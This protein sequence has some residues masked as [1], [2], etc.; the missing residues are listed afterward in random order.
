MVKKFTATVKVTKKHIQQAIE[1]TKTGRPYRSQNCPVALAFVDKGYKNVHVG[2]WQATVKKQG[3]LF[4][5]ELPRRVSAFI[6]R[7]DTAL[8]EGRVSRV[9]PFTFKVTGLTQYR[10]V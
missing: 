10:V 3:K 7:F 5:I 8:A 4:F 9:R 1:Y 2:I 6:N